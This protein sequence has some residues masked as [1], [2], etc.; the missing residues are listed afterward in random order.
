MYGTDL[1]FIQQTA[2]SGFATGATPGILGILRGSEI[3]Q[4]LV[5]DLGCGAGEWIRALTDRGYHAVG[6]EQSRALVRIA[7]A[8]APRASVRAGSVYTARLPSCAA[9][10]ALGEVLSYLPAPPLRQLF[11]RVARALRPNGLFIFDL[12]VRS[13]GRAKYRSWYAGPSWTLCLDV[14]S[15]ATRLTREITTYRWVG[16]AYR[17]RHETHRARLADPKA[18]IR[19][20]TRAGF[21]V[22]TTTRYGRYRLAPGRLA[23]IAHRER[24]TS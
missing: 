6:I 19:E 11:R 15:T 13:A 4:G 8:R 9:V 24:S 22:A 20:L 10:T 1:A 23:F 17:R 21:S 18:V 5:V 14:A 2:F 12:M 3:R 16:G 7:K